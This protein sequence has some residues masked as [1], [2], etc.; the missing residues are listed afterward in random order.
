MYHPDA[1]VAVSW[2]KGMGEEFINGSIASHKRGLRAVHLLGP[3][4]VR[5]KANRATADVGALIVSSSK[6]DGVGCFGMCFARLV[7][8]MR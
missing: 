7:Y 6:V 2:F 5:V 3:P 1:T 4:M 8:R